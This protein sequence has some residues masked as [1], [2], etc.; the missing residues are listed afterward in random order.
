MQAIERDEN[1]PRAMPAV[2]M[3]DLLAACA[4]AAEVSTPPRAPA[5]LPAER[6]EAA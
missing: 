1:T 6:P 2:S 3:R 4:A 5:P